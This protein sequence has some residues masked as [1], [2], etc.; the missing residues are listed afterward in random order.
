MKWVWTW[1]GKCFG[2]LDGEDLWTYDGKHVAR[3]NGE[4]IY[5]KEVFILA[6]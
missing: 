1:S 2:Y 6:S 3:I 5:N 4:E